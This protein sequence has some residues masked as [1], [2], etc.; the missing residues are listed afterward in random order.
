MA[1]S[2]VVVLT[3][4]VIH[5]PWTIAQ[6]ILALPRARELVASPFDP[7]PVLAR[8]PL[9]GDEKMRPQQRRHLAEICGW[10][11][12]PAGLNITMQG[13]VGQTYVILR[14]G[15]AVITA[16]DESGR[17]R[18]Y[19]AVESG[20]A[21][22]E[23]SLLEGKP[24]DATVRA[25][26]SRLGDGGPLLR[27][28]EIVT[29]DRR[30]F[31]YAVRERPH[32]WR[33]PGSLASRLEE[34]S[35]LQR[36]FGWQGEGEKIVWAGR[37]HI[38]WLVGPEVGLA[39]VSVGCA[40]LLDQLLRPAV[41]PS[42]VVA[43]LLTALV[44]LPLAIWTVVN[45]FDDYCVVTT[46][47]V[48]RRDRRLLLYESRVESP[49]E[50]VQNV[51]VDT[52]FWGR[53][54]CFGDLTVR[55]AAKV[56]AIVFAHVPGPD[57]VKG[58]ILAGKGVALAARRS[59]QQEALR[60]GLI[61]EL[62]L[63]L[64]LPPRSRALG[65]DLV[66]ARG[67]RWREHL[68]SITLLTTGKSSQQPLPGS[69][70]SW[71]VR[72][73]ERLGSRLPGRWR[74]VI[75]GPSRSDGALP[76]QIVWRK[77]WLSL[78]QRTALPVLVLVALA[79]A[80]FLVKELAHGSGRLLSGPAGLAVVW[81]GGLVA[82]GALL[83]YQVEDY[84]NDLYVVTDD[85][86]IDI[87]K[88]P[89]GLSAK[90]REGNLDRVQSVDAVQPGLWANLL[91]YGNVVIRTAASDEGFDFVRIGNPKLVQSIIFQRLEALRQRQERNRLAER[92]R[93][94]IEGLRVY[95]EVRETDLGGNTD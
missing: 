67:P 93:E 50:T 5:I 78:V 87:E 95:H 33:Q 19:N 15:R 84:R 43:I 83:W 34:I 73:L 69:R 32:L 49:I 39:L 35:G 21:Y 28:V 80:P 58:H 60:Q 23:T 37:G 74:S 30:D 10:E 2:A 89:L 14:A 40:W 86:I 61:S 56:G 20:Y 82:A 88:R 62:G 66:P 22:G 81:L 11:F 12:V 16:V 1:N 79:L 94:L 25:L 51:T 90:R 92:Q 46:R 53:L 44:F 41:A 91:N 3:A 68:N 45:Y 13:E 48:T 65:I 59:Q 26:A 27:G 71:L 72:G 52:S 85:K 38:L 31:W 76:G 36:F 47:R 8:A 75:F 64:P 57:V 55:T 18:P 4:R 42:L 77:H 7:A 63:A 24:R 17:V 9:F 6:Q 70:R 54:F 29:V